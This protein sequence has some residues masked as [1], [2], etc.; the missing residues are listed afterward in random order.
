MDSLGADC[1]SKTWTVF[2]YY[3][4]CLCCKLPHLW[5]IIAVWCLVLIDMANITL[6]ISTYQHI[7]YDRGNQVQAEGN[8]FM[9]RRFIFEFY[10]EQRKRTKTE[11]IEFLFAGT[12]PL[13]CQDYCLLLRC[14]IYPFYLNIFAIWV[15][16]KL[17]WPWTLF[18]CNHLL[19]DCCCRLDS[20]IKCGHCCLTCCTLLSWFHIRE[21]SLFSVHFKSKLIHCIVSV[22]NLH[23]FQLILKKIYQPQTF[24]EIYIKKK[25]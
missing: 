18:D 17:P 1:A 5:W 20:K 23:Y 12:N 16:V 11:E 4:A 3:F 10:F 24:E 21:L 9:N 19:Q 25:I 13:H 7:Y 8:D 14:I 6:T 22:E 2:F 15:A